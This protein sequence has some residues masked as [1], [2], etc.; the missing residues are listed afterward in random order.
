MH[1]YCATCSELRYTKGSRLSTVAVIAELQELQRLAYR[2]ARLKQLL[3]PSPRE[4]VVVFDLC[5]CA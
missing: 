4:L 5:H 3:Q 2:L 1:S